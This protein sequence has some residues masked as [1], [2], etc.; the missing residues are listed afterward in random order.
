M[1]DEG[2]EI[3]LLWHSFRT[4]MED[5]NLT[6]L[7]KREGEDPALLHSHC[8]IPPSTDM[9]FKNPYCSSVCHVGMFLRERGWE[10]VVLSEAQ[11]LMEGNRRT[12]PSM[13]Y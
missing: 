13:N 1:D 10:D 7:L 3:G 8:C 2:K 4:Q 12:V 5:R 11:Y 9:L 6:F